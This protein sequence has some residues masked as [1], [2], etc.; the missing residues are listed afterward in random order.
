MNPFTLILLV[1]F[2]AHNT[3]AQ[4][5]FSTVH[6]ETFGSGIGTWH[7]VDINDNTDVWTYN[8]SGFMEIN[9]GGGFDDED[10][11]ISPAIDMN[12]QIDEY[13]IFDY[14][15]Y[16]KGSFIELYYSINYNGGQTA[17]DVLSATWTQLPLDLKEIDG[18]SCF[19]GFH[20]HRA[21]DVS[22]I[23]GTAVYFGF[24]YV[25]TA[26]LAK[27]YS[28]D[29]VRIWADY[30]NG[31][32]NNF[33]CCNLKDA[34]YKKISKQT[35][36]T[37]YTSSTKYD[38]WDAMLMSDVRLNDAGTDTIMYCMFTDFPSTTG[39]QEL[40]PCAERNDGTCSS[41]IEGDCYERE[42]TMPSSWWG[43][44]SL[45]SDTMYSDLH[46]LVPADKGLNIAKSN[47]PPGIVETATTTGSNGF[48]VGSNSTYPCSSMSYFEP[49]STYKGDYARMYFFMA[50]RY[51]PYIAGWQTITAEG[52]CA[53]NGDS[54]TVF[55]PWLLQVLLTWHE[56]DPVS[57][58]EIERNNAVYAVQGNR[59]PFIDYPEWIG[60]IWGNSAGATCSQVA[61]PVEFGE[62]TATREETG[63]RLNWETHSELNNSHFE[64]QRSVD[65]YTWESIGTKQG[66][67]TTSSSTHY[68]YLDRS[69][70]I[71]EILYYRIKQM[72]YNGDFDYSQT[73]STLVPAISSLSILP[74]PTSGSVQIYFE[75]LQKDL[76]I[77][78]YNAWG[79]LL[80]TE[81][82]DEAKLIHLQMEGEP[83]IYLVQFTSRNDVNL[84]KRVIK[85]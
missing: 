51:H 20:P 10:W 2:F 18:T 77:V 12:A 46:H 55:E 9:G 82:H 34:I 19:S 60:F 32:P 33:D 7:A 22:G 1:L 73:V 3:L 15:D 57:T 61:L 35:Y 68:S 65:G 13:F 70:P 72:D 83:G 81:H 37:Y 78:I 47:Y 49:I 53:I 54:C 45:R 23:S 74:N 80:Y 17:A 48:K 43:G 67:G 14:N 79:K 5:G 75:E 85:R 66:Q 25:G 40:L 58:K 21:I 59:N 28:I 71:K 41:T 4:Y 56:N 31:L 44:G 6:W 36:H 50:T 42:H 62:L 39:E 63:I 16:F 76:D 69:Y 8:T 64:I 52:N 38:I 30:Y 29:N 11:L 27:N 84:T 24:K 26:S